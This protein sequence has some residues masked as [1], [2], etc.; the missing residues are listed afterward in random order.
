MNTKPKKL[1]EKTLDGNVI[2]TPRSVQE[3]WSLEHG[4]WSL[5][6]GLGEKNIFTPNRKKYLKK[7][8]IFF[9]FFFTAEVS[10]FLITN[11][12]KKTFP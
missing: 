2:I 6:V 8:P 4:A 3:I 9:C 5:R 11:I 7:L 12:Y 10:H 1:G